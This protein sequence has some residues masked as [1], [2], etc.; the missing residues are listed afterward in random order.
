MSYDL[1]AVVPLSMTV[2]DA[3]GAPANAGNMRL[4]VTLPDDTTAVVDPVAPASTGSYSYGYPTVQA[5]L[6]Q[7][8]WVGTGAN[9]CA[10]TDVFDVRPAAA[11]MLF[12]LA[13]AKG[14]LDI[15][16]TSTADDEKLRTY[17]AATT[18]AVEY[19]VGA[20]SRRTVHQVVSGDC[21]AWVLHTTPVL[22]VTA[23]TAVAVWQLDVDPGV[24]DVD[25]EAGILRRTDGLW[26]YSG[27]YRVTYTAGRAVVEPNIT[28]AGELILQHLWR[29]R[30]G[31]A[32][33][34]VSSDDFLVTEA[35]PGFGYAIPNR[36][37]QL[38]QGE[39]EL[40]GFA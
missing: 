33:G 34:A 7:V 20:V 37:L 22:A 35:V 5:G 30:F 21:A 27:D 15:P 31:A 9:A 17:I 28:L 23:V 12:S 10:S 40:G 24:L 36:A 3:T 32:R 14:Q 11:A 38:L 1:G 6:H 19:F 39:R 13:D 26:F 4:T 16:V 18:R 8:R 25:G 2:K 29:T